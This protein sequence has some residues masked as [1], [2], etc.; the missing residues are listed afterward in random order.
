ME[1]K[2]ELRILCINTSA[3]LGITEA[4]I[5]KDYWVSFV[6]DYLFHASKWKETFAFKGGTSLSK[7]FKLIERFSED[8]DLI[9]DWRALG[10]AKDEPWE[11]RSN[12]GQDKFNKKINVK[13]EEFL[14]TKFLP[15]IEE[16][17][18]KL[19]KSEFKLFIDK[20]NPQTVLFEYP[21][22]FSSSYLMQNIRLEIGS[23]AAWDPAIKAKIEPMI[24]E[25]YPNIFKE[26]IEIRTIA[27]ERTFWEKATILHHEANRPKILDMP[28]RYARHYYDLYNMASS[29][30]KESA[31]RDIELMK[32]VANFKIKF[33]PR[34]WAKYEDVLDGKIRLVPDEYRFAKIQEDYDAMKEMMYG[35]YPDFDK[36]MKG[37]KT[38]EIELNK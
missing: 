5:E 33:Y 29:P 10:Y 32:K 38:L 16:D 18:R 30:V 20:E 17:F 3:K 34:K 26:K 12:T 2:D 25:V 27:P 15:E 4:V 24:A 14:K 11:E 6:L 31:I 28:R 1:T 36:L 8:I 37:L 9:L 23:L 7:C 22:I 21:K 19:L 35:A 13:T